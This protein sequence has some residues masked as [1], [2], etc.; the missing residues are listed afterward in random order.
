MMNKTGIEETAQAVVD[1]GNFDELASVFAA[2]NET[3]DRLR[4]SHQKLQKEIARLRNEL[5]QKNEQLE[6]KNRLA[7]LGQMAAGMAHEIRNPLGGVQLYAS[8]LERDL[9]GRQEQLNWAQKISKGVQTLDSIVNDILAFTQDQICNK[10]EVNLAGLLQE[11]LDYLLP[12]TSVENIK[13]DL[14]EVDKDLT[15][16]VDT[17]MMRRVFFNLIRNALDAIEGEG[18]VKIC[19]GSCRK[20]P[21]YRIRISVS[22]DGRGIPTEVMN[23]M[24]NPFY[25]TKDTGTGLGLTIVHRLVEVQGGLISGANNET[26]GAT[27]TILLP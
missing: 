16:Q 21:L 18:T 20:N 25:T 15:V 9:A 13:I 3:T 23:K 24:F 14:D 8:L 10:T 6:R 5:Q 7:A 4:K 1:N 22:D 2:Y 11:T 19:A 27:F 26:V 17:N 12:Q